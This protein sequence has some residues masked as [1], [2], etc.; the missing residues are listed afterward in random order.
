[1]QSV[2]AYG[3]AG[4]SVIQTWQIVSDGTVPPSTAAIVEVSAAL[5]REYADATT[6]AVFATGATCGAITMSGNAGTNSYDSS[7][8]LVSGAPV[9]AG[10]GGNVGTN[11]NLTI[12][13]SV[14]AYGTLSTPRTGA[15]TC[16]NGAVDA[17]T[18]T[19]S[20]TVHSGVVQ[21]PQ[22]VS[23]PTPA[24]P[25]TTNLTTAT[26][27]SSTPTC[28]SA[29]ITVTLP[30][31]C[32]A[33]AGVVTV[34]TNGVAVSI[35]N[36]TM[37]GGTLN[38]VGGTSSAATVNINSITLGGNAQLSIG[39]GTSVTMN[40][41]GKTSTGDLAVPVDLTGGADI[42]AS[43]DPSRLQILYAGTGE[44][45]LT[46]GNTIAAT[47]YAPAASAD[48]HGNGKFYG[49]ILSATFTDAGN[50]NFYYDRNLQKKFK[51]LGNYMMT[52]FSW[53]K[54]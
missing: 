52:S 8:A 12:T 42:N 5:E 2:T 20:A 6:Y 51:T 23:F 47:I 33:A 4:S 29:G 35:G 28:A 17:L 26:I 11:G 14:D 45:K 41:G 16:N 37:N 44:I 18:S 25:P 36:L 13:G 1:M 27:S 21:L 34:T 15:G 38:I 3:A 31:L 40:V 50:T 39:S 19:G 7:A 10:S 46:G 24:G 54:Y 48:T 53:K 9:L 22:S 49:S 32:T 43:F 30:S